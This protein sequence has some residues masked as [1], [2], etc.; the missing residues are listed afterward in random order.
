MMKEDININV[1]SSD[2]INL[3]LLS[4]IFVLVAAKLIKISWKAG[5]I[6]FMY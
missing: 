4:I 3:H 6:N 5:Y 2:L 1:I